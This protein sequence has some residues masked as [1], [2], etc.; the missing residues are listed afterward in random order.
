ML[1]S[2]N[3]KSG[4]VTN[5]ES[6]NCETYIVCSFETLNVQISESEHKREVHRLSQNSNQFYNWIFGIVNFKL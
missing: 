5:F 3:F 4:F 2:D 1:A 6:L